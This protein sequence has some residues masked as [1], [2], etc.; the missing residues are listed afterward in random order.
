MSFVGNNKRDVFFRAMAYYALAASDLRIVQYQKAN[1]LKRHT[2]FAFVILDDQL[3]KFYPK[4]R[5]RSDLYRSAN[6]QATGPERRVALFCILYF[7]M[8]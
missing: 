5:F 6:H 2:V 4:M 8:S 3:S 1:V 7:L